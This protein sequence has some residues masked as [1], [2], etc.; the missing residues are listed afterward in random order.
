MAE[1]TVYCP[2]C[3]KP[4]SKLATVCPN[5]GFNLENFRDQK[6]QELSDEVVPK[7]KHHLGWWF[8]LI[9]LFLATAGY[10]YGSNLYSQEHQRQVLASDLSSG[11]ASRMAKVSIDENGNSLDAEDLSPLAKLLDTSPHNKKI[12]K[13]IIENGS[14]NTNFNVV[15]SG[16]FYGFIP[17][18]KV[19]LTKQP[20]KV[21]TDLDNPVFYLNNKSIAASGNEDGY[22]LAAHI[23]GLYTVKAESLVN[24][25]KASH[26]LTIPL[27]DT[28]DYLTLNAPVKKQA[29]K[30]TTKKAKT[31][32]ADSTNEKADADQPVRTD[33]ILGTWNGPNNSQF[34][35]NDDGTY[36]LNNGDNS[37]TQSGQYQIDVING[38]RMT[39]VFK[40]DGDEFSGSADTF[41][42]NGDQM[43][44][45]QQNITWNK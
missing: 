11:D 25:K 34:T 9:I 24:G 16:Q 41:V 32:P 13:R 8:F 36:Q 39:I 22:S 40:Q 44:Q 38:N 43:Q 20:I 6:N 14:S 1:E 15:K 28:P 7:K 26:K 2:N 35:F 31:D 29:K 23:P 19:K 5:C 37:D 18:Y 33:A 4:V 42:I 17:R 10:F 27:T 45:E 3:G 30:K 21:S 12:V